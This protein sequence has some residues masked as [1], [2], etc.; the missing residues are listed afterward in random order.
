MKIIFQKKKTQNRIE[1]PGERDVTPTFQPQRIRSSH[2]P[3]DWL[4][5]GRRELLIGRAVRI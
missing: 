3:F 2:T 5:S 4:K 1:F